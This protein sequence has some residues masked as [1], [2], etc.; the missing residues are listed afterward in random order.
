MMHAGLFGWANI[1]EVSVV[2][3][4]YDERA[5]LRDTP[6][7]VLALPLDTELLCA[8]YGSTVGS[9]EFLSQVTTRL[10]RHVRD[11]THAGPT[12]R[13]TMCSRSMTPRHPWAGGPRPSGGNSPLHD[14]SRPERRGHNRCSRCLGE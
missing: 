11:L 12:F 10:E 8:D 14:Q 4:V 3:P 2:M 1:V 5:T 7:R 13:R 6:L 9:R